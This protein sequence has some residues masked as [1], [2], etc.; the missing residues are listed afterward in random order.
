MCGISGIYS[1]GDC[2]EHYRSAVELSVQSLKNRGPE[3]QQ[4]AVAGHAV[5]G[6]ARLAILDTSMAGNQPFTDSSKRYTIVY[7]GEFY[8]YR[9]YYDEL[10]ADGVQF[11][12]TSDTEVLLQLYI[13]YGPAFIEKINGF[14]AFAIYDSV[15]DVLFIARDRIGIKPLYYI[16]NESFFG[17][18]SE[19]KGIMTFPFQ[20]ALNEIALAAYLQLNYVP[21]PF[22]MLENVM[23]LE[24][25]M[26]I[27]I[28]GKNVKKERYYSIPRYNSSA[29]PLS[30]EEAQKQL[31]QKLTDS[32][33]LRLIS[34]VP[35]GT[36]L[37]GGIDSSVISTI[38]S[39]YVD[40]L[41]TFSIGFKDN[42]FIDETH[43]AQLVAKKIHSQHT[44][45]Q[46]DNKT[47][48][49][50]LYAI[51]QNIDEPFADSSA[52]AVHV[53]CKYVKP[54]VTVALSGDGADELFAGY[55]KHMAHY[56]QMQHGLLNNVASLSYPLLKHLPQSRSNALYNVF[57]KFAKY[58]EG[59]SLSNA[60][61][62]W[63]WCSF[64]DEQVVKRE[65]KNQTI[66]LIELKQKYTSHFSASSDV[67]DVLYGDQLLVLPNDMLTK[68]DR[69]SM[70]N[71]LEVRTPF[72]DHTLVTFINSLPESYKID[73]RMKK[74]IL[75]D[76]FRSDLP[77]ELYNRP[78][79]G[80]EVPLQSWCETELQDLIQDLLSKHFIEEQGIFNYDAIAGLK[81]VKY[82]SS[83]GDA[84][85]HIWALIVFQSWWKHYLQ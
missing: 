59:V 22:T 58:A 79:K 6:H 2:A 71:S 66:S 77:Q 74:K 61:A 82:M 20:R 13:K 65:L 43:Y 41:Q 39:R 35:L 30:Y 14:F 52:I 69:M 18:S 4:V 44:E 19:L 17:F 29:V 72:L 15:K 24:P 11:Q 27:T 56:K 51:L 80:F 46:I 83:H 78:K 75:Q 36:F 48:Q 3:V 28:S 70:D 57:R 10:R 62:Y 68:T 45:I 26:S 54:H 5:L 67:N 53:L 73:G 55:H 25:G 31:V 47:L 42:P 34:D 76:A 84:P 16:E 23:K 37:S 21:A 49:E 40:S 50:S 63:K 32:V 81:D 7:N 60:D 12:S 38:A 33:Q 85:A 9:E 64:T 8:N 1:F